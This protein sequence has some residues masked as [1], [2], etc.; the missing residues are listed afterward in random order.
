MF[1]KHSYQARRRHRMQKCLPT[2]LEIENFEGIEFRS[3]FEI[4][5]VKHLALTSQVIAEFEKRIGT[6]LN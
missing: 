5:S 3:L 1:R 4:L 2:E 6:F